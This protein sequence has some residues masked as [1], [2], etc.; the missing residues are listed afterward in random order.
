MDYLKAAPALLKGI[1]AVLV[2]ATPLL[3]LLLR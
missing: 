3:A 2:A 1:A